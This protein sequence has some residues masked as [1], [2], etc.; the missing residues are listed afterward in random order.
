VRGQEPLRG[1]EPLRGQ[2]K[3]TTEPV[4]PEPPGLGPPPKETA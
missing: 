3:V 2:E 1:E 4:W